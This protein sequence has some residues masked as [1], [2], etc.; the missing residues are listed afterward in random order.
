MKLWAA[1]VA[2]AL[3]GISGP[4]TTVSIPPDPKAYFL[5]TRMRTSNG[6]FLP[7]ERM[8]NSDYCGHC[9]TQIFHEWDASTHHFSSFNNPVYRNVALSTIASHGTDTFKICASCHDPLPLAAGQIPATNLNQWSYTA[10][11]TCLSCHRITEVHGHNG[12]YTVSAPTLHPFA[13]S[14]HP[15]QQ[16][17]HRWLLGAFPSLH[18]SVLS[19]PAYKTAEFCATCH[20]VVAT[21]QTN[22]V[23]D[24]TL[25]N[26]YA[27]WH[28]SS[29]A[30]PAAGR[31]TDTSCVDCHMPQVASQ[32]PAAK[33]GL[34][35]SHR[36]LGGNTL[37]P[38]LNR[39]AD[40]LHATEAFL[41]S[42]A[43]RLRCRSIARVG[44]AEQHCEASKLHHGDSVQLEMEIAN[45]GVGH[46]FPGGTSDSNQVWM[47]VTV[48]DA[49]DRVLLHSGALTPE[50]DPDGSA[51][52]LRTVYVD[53]DGHTLDRRSSST[54]AAARSFS[55]VLT[56]QERRVVTYS[57]HLD[58]QVRFPLTI[59]G[60]L[61]WRKFPVSFLQSVFP[62]P[63]LPEAPITVISETTA[64]VDGA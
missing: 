11:L 6:E 32:D 28:R 7:A 26:E 51:Y 12:A 64:R 9:H 57:L 10:G 4:A 56:P 60:R 34:A 36:F 50:G 15:W 22:G 49:N 52:L 63:D 31:E 23:G 58:A 62:A 44:A 14:D 18:R 38:H 20:T 13:F 47:E 5:S 30:E 24:I 3:L 55:N 2:M 59:R 17:L 54:S 40:Q 53:R 16:R 61:N 41:R 27:S 46:D 39:D 43:V 35:R 1:S 29:F 33:D 42:G 45:V 21:Q 48:S 37:L 8:G 25:Q 19:K